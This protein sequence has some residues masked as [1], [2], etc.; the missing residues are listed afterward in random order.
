MPLTPDG[1]REAANRLPR[2]Q[3]AHSPTPL[4]PCDRLSAALGDVRIWVKREDCTGLAF[5][6]NKTRQLEFTLGEAMHEQADCIV[7][8]AGLQSNHCRQTAA[9]CA[10]LGLACV[11]CLARGD[12]EHHVQGNLLLDYLFG[13]DVRFFDASMGAEL[14]AA[15]Q[16][17]AAELRSAGRRPYLIGEPR[18]RILGAI[19][20]AVVAAEL[21]D[22]FALQGVAPDLLYVASA[23]ATG[24]GLLA[25]FRALGMSLPITAIAPIRWPH[26]TAAV[27]AETANAAGQALGVDLG[28]R[29]DDVR[30]DEGYIGAEYGVVTREGKA[31]L[32]LMARTEGILLD[33]VY[34]S[35]ALAGLIDHIRTGRVPPGAS[36]VFIH[37]GGTPAL[38]SHAGEL[39]G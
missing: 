3:L 2:V 38:F 22:Q 20:C 27:M 18:G 32:D 17:V 33:P 31:A 35:K 37:T 8:G 9:A 29:R 21:A 23:G 5:G 15:K 16:G 10:R 28:L 11:L 26:D 19:G 25:G 36:V 14:E 13:A 34:S 12:H 7:Q 6:G 24:S 39:Q 1:L 30:L 4:E